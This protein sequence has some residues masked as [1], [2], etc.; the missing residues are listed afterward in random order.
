MNERLA[1]IDKNIS[2]LRDELM[3]NTKEQR[4]RFAMEHV[5]VNRF[6][7]RDGNGCKLSDVLLKQILFSFHRWCGH[8][9]P[10]VA[11]IIYVMGEKAKP[12][13][14]ELLSAQIHE[15]TGVKP[16]FTEESGGK[17]A[18]YFS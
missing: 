1:G 16:R 3:A 7:Y 9:L 4:I 5:S 17:R 6:G 14:E 11:Q 8:Y 2:S 13:F 18:V 10:T 15:L 12:K